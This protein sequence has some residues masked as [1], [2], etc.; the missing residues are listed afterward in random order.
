MIKASALV[1]IC[2][3]ASMCSMAQPHETHYAKVADIETDEIRI[4]IMDQHSQKTFTQFT[5]RIYNKTDGYIL[6]HREEV[7]FIYDWGEKHMMEAVLFI[8][9]NGDITRL[10]RVEGGEDFRQ[11]HLKIEFGNFYRVAR[12]GVRTEPKNFSIPPEKKS[13]MDGP[14]AITALKW[15]GNAKE[16]FVDFKIR[17]RGEGLGTLLTSGIKI[18]L[19]DGSMV[20]NQEGVNT[21]FFLTPNK[22]E[23]IRV[24]HKFSKGE[25]GTKG[26]F[27]A[28]FTDALYE[29]ASES[30]A[31]PSV[32]LIKR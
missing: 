27:E 29:T 14:F 1:L 2:L 26:S 21:P 10:F 30:F 4:E 16:A 7:K 20:H 13:I 17:Y 24:I 22:A 32:E 28:V 9:P 18:Q 31:V 5:A 23:V 15:N 8:E 6:I 3:C 25:S 19:P 11:D 12:E